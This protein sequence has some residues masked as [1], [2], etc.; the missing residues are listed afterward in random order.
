[1]KG[2]AFKLAVL[3]S[4]GDCPGLNAALYAVLQRAGFYGW[5][6]WG[7]ERG[8]HGLLST[9]P[10]LRQLTLEAFDRN[11]P[12]QGG[13]FLGTI[14][15]G[16]PFAFPT[17][18][19][20]VQD[21]SDAF[22]QAFHQLG[23][24]G[25]IGIAGDGSFPILRRLT[26]QGQIPFIGIP[27]TIDNDV[28]LTDRT[29]GFS[30]AVEIAT[31]ALDHLRPTAA[32]HQRLM[33]LEVMGRNTGHIALEAGIAGGADCILI[34][35]IPYTLQGILE[36]LNRLKAQGQASG[37]M[38]VAEGLT[39]PDCPEDT[40]I[41]QYLAQY[42]TQQGPYPARCTVLGHVQRGAP[43]C[44]Q[45]RVLA[46]AFGVESVTLLASGHQD[47][48]VALQKGDFTHVPLEEV[49]KLRPRLVTP[50]A[51]ALQWVQAILY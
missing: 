23:F 35:E 49:V 51:P 14:N 9:P 31:Q 19:G 47:R 38:V 12:A 29:I 7:I 45:D 1:M 24:D 2:G 34:P 33:I 42:L 16:D 30:S 48:M 11:L 22:I 39:H 8:S 36:K 44:A 26:Q 17:E 4:G 46:Q 20:G 6:V 18:K 3:T 21:R 28:P 15:R 41:G 50:D 5:E 40:P 43:P 13:S 25:L 27:K 32:S 37:L 10:Q